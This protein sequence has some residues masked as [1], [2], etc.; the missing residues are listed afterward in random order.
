MV[1]ALLYEILPNHPETL[2]KFREPGNGKR[3]HVQGTEK[4][5]LPK[6]ALIC[7]WPAGH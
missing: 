1:K 7:L 2:K 4:I 6:E 5:F 3:N